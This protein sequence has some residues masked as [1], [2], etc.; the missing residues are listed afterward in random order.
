MGNGRRLL[1]GLCGLTLLSTMASPLRAA[2]PAAPDATTVKAAAAHAAGGKVQGWKLIE[3]YC[4]ECHNAEDWAGSI[5]FDV[6]GEDD[7]P[8]QAEVM[9]KVVRK[10]RSQQMPPGGNEVPDKDAR[11]EFISWME[12]RLDGA[13]KEHPDPG[14]VGLHRLNRKEYA[15]AVRDLLNI[16]VDAAALLP[17]D[18]PREGFDNIAAALQVA[19]AFLDQYIAASRVVAVQAMGNK[20]AQPAGTVYRQK[21]PSTQF[22]HEDGLPLGTRGG[23]AADHNFPA[24]GEYVLNIANMALAL[25]VYNM[26]FENTLVVT[27]DGEQLYET[28]IGGEDD[29]KAIDQKQDPAV[30]AI[31]KRLKNIRFNAK[32]GVHRLVVAFR[33]R[34][35]AES[36]DRLQMHV[37]GGGQDRVLRVTQFE[38]RGPFNATGVSQTAARQHIFK[39]CY[40]TNAAEERPCAEKVIAGFAR[41]A[42]RRPVGDEDLK[43]LLGFYDAGRKASDFDA[44]IRRAITAVLAHPDFLFRSDTPAQALPAGTIYA[45]SDLQLASRLSFFLWSSIP[46]DELLDV[47]VAGR[48]RDPG[49][50]RTQVRRMLADPR[51]QTLASNFGYQWL[52]LSKLDEIVPEPSVFP[53]ASGA[54][55]L[56]EDFKTELALFM[57]DVFRGDRSVLDLLASDT[58]FVNERLALHYGINDV[59]GDRF[60][61][62]RLTDSVRHGLLGKGGVLMVSAY[63]NRT[64]PVLRGAFVLERIMGTPPPI[65]P[66]AVEALKENEAGKKAQTV[67][68]R[69]ESHR[70]KPQ[71]YSCHAALDPLGFALEGFDAV[72]KKRD[73][74][75]FA[76]TAI[77][78][79][80]ELPD[81]TKV[82]GPVD[83]RNALV[84]NPTMFVQNVTER[85]MMYGIGRVIEAHD[86]PVVR[87]IVRK[88]A[89]DQY[90]F[91]TLVMNI[92]MSDAFQK[93]R[94]PVEAADAPVIKQAANQR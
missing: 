90:K 29:M 78:T 63:P 41:R 59:R 48:L 39:A 67:R 23:I 37:P 61:K 21:S 94:V 65:P 68:E 46:D 84:G 88:S 33:H 12:G 76:R 85:L 13:A 22:F 52:N 30:D 10:L 14:H 62:V 60:R 19:P 43:P 87:D 26:E 42:F 50:L 20:D 86:M 24:D 77:D 36:E 89:A 32:A 31:N 17:R 44:G 4:L 79:A 73:I 35:F 9:E 28:T 64:S 92:V 58:T 49:T 93:S 82:S 8:G 69:L 3:K 7:I 75:R 16:E 81:G 1:A 56:R 53:Y 74:D 2:A 5:A 47:A 54:G 57:D 38:V 34:S 25:W 6:L 40:P 71:C 45:L 72:G 70:E 51:A 80:G 27:L 91:S 11:A 66:P 15:N 18:E 83:L 55:D